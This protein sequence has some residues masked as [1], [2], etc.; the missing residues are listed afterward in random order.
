MDRCSDQGGCTLSLSLRYLTATALNRPV[1]KLPD[2]NK[3]LPA[4]VSTIKRSCLQV[5][6]ILII[7]KED[8][9]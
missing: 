6:L 9:F 3:R 2:Q 5:E 7:K 1:V 8:L 4:T